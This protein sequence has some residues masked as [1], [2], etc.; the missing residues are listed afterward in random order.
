MVRILY[1]LAHPLMA[2]QTNP[3]TSTHEEKWF[4]LSQASFGKEFEI[5]LS[6]G[7]ICISTK[8]YSL[9]MHFNGNF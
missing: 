2:T 6:E 5:F 7:L 4:C 9:I 8:P 3:S 1:I